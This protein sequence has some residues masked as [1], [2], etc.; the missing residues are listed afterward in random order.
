MSTIKLSKCGNH[1]TAGAT[2]RDQY[3]L[4]NAIARAIKLETRIS[5]D[6]LAMAG[7]SKRLLANI[8][9]LPEPYA[10]VLTK[11]YVDL[12]SFDEIGESLFYS[13]DSVKRLCAT[14]LDK[15]AEKF[16]DNM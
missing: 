8:A 4:K 9:S 16:C 1:P 7:E 14:G 5:N 15:Y 10:T 13:G 11:R 12:K 3:L 2:P 6:I